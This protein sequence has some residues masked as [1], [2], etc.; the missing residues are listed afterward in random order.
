LRKYFYIL[1]ISILA[2]NQEKEKK[3]LNRKEIETKIEA[4]REKIRYHDYHYHVLDEPLIADSEYDQLM[5][6]LI[7]L[8]EKF[9]Q[10]I[11][12]SSPTQRV[13]SK[14]LSGFESVTHTRPMLSL[15]N[16]FSSDELVAF[17][18]RIKKLLPKA[19]IDYVVE[20]KI[21]GLAVS[22]VY[23][24]GFF[25]RGA[26]R[27]D[28]ITGEDIT[29][30]LRTIKSIPLKLRGK[31][32][33]HILE[34]YG[35]VYMKKSDFKKLNS[36]R[37]QAGEKIFANPRNASAGSVR[38][39]EPNITAQRPLDIFIYRANIPET[40]N[41]YRHV[42]VLDY[43]KQVGFKVNLNIKLC[44]NIN[45]VIS[46]CSE[47]INK[48]EILDYEIDGMVIKVN[49]LK[50]REELGYTTR[51]PRWAIAYKFPAQQA[52]TKI[53]DIIV[54]VGSTGAITPVAEFVEQ[55][56]IS[57]SMVKRATLHNEEE[58]RRK[59]IRIGDTVLIQK[60]GE[61]IPEVVK[62]IKEER[63]GKEKKFVMPTH[64]R[65]CG[66]KLVKPEGEVIFRC[67][68]PNCPDQVRGRIR[69][70]ASRDAMDIEG[71][72]PAI[73]AQLVEKGL[74]KDISDLYF[75]KREDLI[76]LERMAKKSAD[77]LLDAIKKSKKKSLSNLIYG[78]EMRY[79]GVHTSEV[80]TRH[81]STL[82]KFKKADLEEL[83]EI[84]EIGPKIAKS[85]INFFENEKNLDIIERL[86]DA[87]LN[88]GQEGKKI[89]EGKR[90]QIL[91]GKQFVLTGTLKDFTRDEAGR[92][93]K[94]L[95]GRVTGSVSKK[96]DYVVVGENPGSKYTTAKELRVSIINEQEFKKLIA[97]D[98]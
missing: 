85:I 59:D 26:T 24:N 7:H 53:K 50:L 90:V 14:P 8:E 21:D 41:F 23:E 12:F 92:R 1:I 6:E 51:S 57:G 18:K 58:I 94:E 60:A 81:Y 32:I 73:I 22:L 11:T 29:S 16:A 86:R 89:S 54:Q 70:F 33:P 34:V 66:T 56:P 48:K 88:F 67:I 80:I 69:H 87:G 46:Y 20:L 31:N 77:N 96:T 91:A 39:L 36:K 30:N 82:D 2:N 95:G 43:L 55:V 9:P 97:I 75:L 63:T 72:G 38:Q 5:R 78:L 84:K 44:K 98:K 37:L 47:W 49:S 35:E 25:V 19:E 42:E 74:I 45:E 52:T 4:L 27:G 65:V 61:V 64:C 17:D 71:L 76:S 13:G 62:V 79:V 40:Y 10:L 28:G 93:I 15:S 83:I 68:N 3:L